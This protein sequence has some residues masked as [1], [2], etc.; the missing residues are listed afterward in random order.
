MCILTDEQKRRA[1]YEETSK[2]PR[3][4]YLEAQLRAALRNG[5]MCAEHVKGNVDLHY[6]WKDGPEGTIGEVHSDAAEAKLVEIARAAVW[7]ARTSGEGAVTI[8]VRKS[9][10]EQNDAQAKG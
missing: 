1:F 7:H 6:A 8:T 9:K 4:K 2:T 5:S 3:E 10:T